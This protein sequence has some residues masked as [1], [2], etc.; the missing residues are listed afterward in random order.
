MDSNLASAPLIS[1]IMPVYNSAP[2]L[3]RAIESILAQ[4]LGDFE[5]LIFNDGST[6]N[7]A[8][9]IRSY[10]DDRITFYDSAV[11]LGYIHWLNEGIKAAKGL[12]LARM[13]SDDIAGHSRLEKQLRVFD[14]RPEI[15]VCG[16]WVRT[17]GGS[18]TETWKYAVDDEEI[19][20]DFLFQ[21]PIAHPAV[22][23][24]K[25][26]L[27]QHSL[28]YEPK[29]FPA[30]DYFLWYQLSQLTA[31]YN[32]PEV[33]LRYRLHPGQASVIHDQGM[34]SAKQTLIKFWILSGLVQQSEVAELEDLN[35]GPWQRSKAYLE[36]NHLFINKLISRNQQE[37]CYD[38]A[39]FK[40]KIHGLFWRQCYFA[41]K[42]GFNGLQFFKNRVH[43]SPFKLSFKAAAKGYFKYLLSNK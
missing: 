39:Q 1:I 28:K 27:Q 10:A 20:L 32:I 21:N 6:D 34:I 38:D 8:A 24:R 16:S 12:F 15:G 41:T 29:F 25:S 37:R 7:S 9:I 19:K 33:L 3:R 31:F 42:P 5:F 11:N 40:R 2:F 22:M 36:K 30:E 14:T 13:D 18:I 17:F 26:V 43:G 4:S 35:F 23:I